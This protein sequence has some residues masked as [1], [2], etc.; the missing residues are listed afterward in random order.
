M[1]VHSTSTNQHFWLNVYTNVEF[2]GIYSSSCSSCQSSANS[3]W[4]IESTNYNKTRLGDEEI[5]F[6]ANVYNKQK[7]GTVDIKGRFAKNE[8]FDIY[9]QKYGRKTTIKTNAMI[10]E[11]VN[12][13]N[14]PNFWNGFIGLAPYTR[15]LDHKDLNFM[16]QL[17]NH[18]MIDHNI[19]SF[20]MKEE[21]G[22]VS[23]IKFGSYDEESV[24]D[25][26]KMA[27]YKTN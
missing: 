2:M 15:N 16:W 26:Q 18:S 8:A 12:P 4:H 20:Y 1:N 10:V 13:G 19:V 6:P 7:V 27:L 11:S 5:S 9:F 17:K 3:Q 21:S 22:N 24:A 25:G 14:Y 23:S